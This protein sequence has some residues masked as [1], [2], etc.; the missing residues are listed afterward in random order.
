MEEFMIKTLKNLFAKRKEEVR[1]KAQE[2]YNRFVK[3]QNEEDDG[4][5][6]YPPIKLNK[7]DWVTPNTDLRADLKKKGI[8][9]P[10]KKCLRLETQDETKVRQFKVINPDGS[11]TDVD[12]NT[13]YKW[14]DPAAVEKDRQELERMLAQ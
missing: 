2:F 9:P 6:T 1:Q 8:K 14:A 4:L 7:V 10:D 12:I 3:K 11:Y 13:W 5:K